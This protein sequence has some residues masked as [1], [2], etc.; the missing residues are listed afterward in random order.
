MTEKPITFQELRSWIGDHR[1]ITISI[2]N[3]AL[4][5]AGS[6]LVALVTEGSVSRQAYAEA[7]GS[8]DAR[9]ARQDVSTP[10]ASGATVR[11]EIDVPA[12]TPR[13]RDAASRRSNTVPETTAARVGSP[14]TRR[15]SRELGVTKQPEQAARVPRPAAPVYGGAAETDPLPDRLQDMPLDEAAEVPADAGDPGA[16]EAGTESGDSAAAPVEWEAPPDEE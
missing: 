13:A 6:C 2:V 12:A 1:V 9:L 5:I 10:E 8:G 7:R 11:H 4:I 16:F 3:A 15:G 14:Q